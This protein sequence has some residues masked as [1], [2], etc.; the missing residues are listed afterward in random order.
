MSANEI[1]LKTPYWASGGVRNGLDA[2]KLL[3]IGAQKVGLA[4]PMLK[5]AME[6]SEHLHQRM[7]L[8]DFELKTAMFCL[9]VENITSL[10]GNDQLWKV[11]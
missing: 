7:E 3:A 9:G 6:S 11:L 2:C 8:L 10:V 4:Q 1:G 5:A